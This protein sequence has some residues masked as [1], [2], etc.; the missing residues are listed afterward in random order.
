[1]NHLHIQGT[2]C[3]IPEFSFNTAVLLKPQPLN[4]GCLCCHRNTLV[5]KHIT[6]EMG[7]VKLRTDR[8]NPF[9]L[10]IVS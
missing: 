7:T 4:L 9:Y 5:Y 6:S 10:L 2:G 3:K 1:M 8:L